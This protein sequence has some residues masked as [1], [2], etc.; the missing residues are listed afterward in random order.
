M[1]V[2]KLPNHHPLGWDVQF[3]AKTLP[4]MFA[5]TTARRLSAPLIHF[6]GRSYG[7]SELYSDAVGFAAGLKD[8]GI[9]PGDR[10]GLFL[11]NVPIYVAAYYGAMMAGAVVVNFSP[12]YSVEELSQQVADSGT[13][14]L[15]TVDAPELY[16]TAARVLGASALETLVVGRI[17][18]MLPRAKGIAMRLFARSKIA[19]VGWS[20]QVVDWA[21]IRQVARWDAWLGDGPPEDA[22][23]DPEA[24]ALLQYTGGTTGTP[25]GAMLSHANLSINAQ[26]V[27][28]INPFDE[29]ENEVFMG[30]LP[31]FHVFANTALLNHAVAS[32]GSIAIVPRFETK[33]VLET[34][35]K[36]RCTGFPGVPTMFQAMLDHP[37][38]AKT[39]LSSLKVCISGG[40]P[41]PAPLREQWEETTG[42]RL[43]E[44]YGLTESAGVVSA[45]P[46]RGTRKPGTIGQVVAGTEVLLLDKEDPTV[47]APDGEPG[48]LAI[49]GPQVMEGYWN[50]PDAAKDVFVEHNGKRWLRTGD[51]ATLDDEGFLEIVDRIKDMIA[52]GGFKVF[53]SQVEDVLL[54]HEAVK[55]AL[56]IGVPDDYKGE[57]P[58]AYATLRKD[59]SADGQALAQWL[60]TRVGK[61]ER[62][63]EVVVR[64]QLPKT[65]IGKLDRKALRAEVL[66]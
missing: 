27:A 26:Q 11:P 48:E 47:L 37:D 34:I 23:L 33:Q 64:E 62:V 16:D 44:G 49:H 55:E 57:V 17:A 8:R 9:A 51:V 66:D 52:V 59:A 10:V 12:L 25:K 46:Y 20:E 7:Y 41:L 63:D 6:M 36:H 18:D 19:R 13:R 54:E 14:M 38:L 2:S 15:V 58:R 22:P 29:P 31:M 50:R 53:P 3:E 32:G 56:V 24:L 42:V 60:N 45:N 40:A 28:A 4:Q 65:M 5:E 21:D 39:D 43:V 30:A 35:E 61:H 1:D